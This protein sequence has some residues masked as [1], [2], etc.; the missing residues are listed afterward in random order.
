MTVQTD[1]GMVTISYV[2]ATGLSLIVLTWCAMF[3]I[4]SYARASI[5]GAS[6]RATR[7][8]IVAYTSTHD[9]DVA[10]V[11]CQNTFE[12][13]LNQGLHGVV[14]SEVSGSCRITAE[15]ISVHTTGSLDSV[16]ALFPA[17]DVNETTSRPFEKIPS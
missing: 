15:A 14:R 12:S 7:A 16:S 10:R 5:R 1:E 2:L 13:D 6:E 8:G 11:A 17:F 4:M 9:L 3:I